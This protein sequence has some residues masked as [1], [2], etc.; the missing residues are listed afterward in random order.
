MSSKNTSPWP[1]SEIFSWHPA[2]CGDD[3]TCARRALDGFGPVTA[4]WEAV[5][6]AEASSAGEQ[7]AQE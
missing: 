4:K 1:D 7:L 5:G 2:R 6:E 3:A